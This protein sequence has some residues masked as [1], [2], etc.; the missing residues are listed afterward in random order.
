MAT[1]N[2]QMLTKTISK[3]GG[4]KLTI[5]ELE[6]EYIKMARTKEIFRKNFEGLKI[7]LRNGIAGDELNDLIKELDKEVDTIIEDYSKWN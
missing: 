7:Q 2:Q 5:Q 3:W 6:E 1:N 4:E